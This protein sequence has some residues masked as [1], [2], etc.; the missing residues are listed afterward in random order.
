MSAEPEFK[1]QR[2]E[3]EASEEDADLKRDPLQQPEVDDD[4]DD[5]NNGEEEE[6]DE[7]KHPDLG[8]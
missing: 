7:A 1:R 5:G 6:Q 8:L 2:M 4:H 3:S